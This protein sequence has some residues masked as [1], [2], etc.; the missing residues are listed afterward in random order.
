MS[1]EQFNSNKDSIEIIPLDALTSEQVT[2]LTQ[3][4][5]KSREGVIQDLI[6]T[7]IAYY[8]QPHVLDKV[9]DDF[10][11]RAANPFLSPGNDI[12]EP[13]HE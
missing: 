13:P 2:I 3:L 8:S 7:G 5:G 1:P 12:P 9:V 10:A 6:A 4:L 11:D